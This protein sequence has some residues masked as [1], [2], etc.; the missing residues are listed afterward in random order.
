[1]G[2]A[3]PPREKDVQPSLEKAPLYNIYICIYIYMSME[4][5]SE[6]IVYNYDLFDV[7]LT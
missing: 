4:D 1:M 3:F 5:V 6:M 7:I 2:S